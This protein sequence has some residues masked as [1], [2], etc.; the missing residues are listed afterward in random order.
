M[1]TSH[2]AETYDV[3][4]FERATSSY[5]HI[6]PGYPA[7]AVDTLIGACEASGLQ[8]E[9]PVRI[10]DI[11]AGT[12]KMTFAL[13]RREVDVVAVEPA[14]A[15]R[16]Q[17][18]GVLHGH[19]VADNSAMNEGDPAA[20]GTPWHQAHSGLI[21]VIDGTGERTTLPDRSVDG[22]V[23]A[24]SWHWVD[25]HEASAE[26]ARIVRPGG[27]VAAVFNQMDV[28]MPWVH[29]L[30]RIMRSGDVHRPDKPPR[31]DPPITPATLHTCRWMHV[32]L[33]EQVM[34]LAR[35]RSSYLRASTAMRKRMQRNLHWYLYEH[36]RYESDQWVSI[37][38]VTM[39]WIARNGLN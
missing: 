2:L 17:L 18:T 32:L 35:T 8:T 25:A 23:F 16:D 5:G 33:P 6:R 27:V 9:S 12:G 4:P 26:L 24:Q 31:W 28:R 36:L 3:N 1:P 14:R 37:P 20:D 29:R 19:D 30:T 10:A 21:R 13:A 22:A 11:G 39:T 7:A 34:E 15:M 38:V